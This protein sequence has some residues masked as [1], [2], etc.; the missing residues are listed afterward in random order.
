MV[1]KL[2]VKAAVFALIFS[3]WTLYLQP[4]AMPY[5]ASQVK[6]EFAAYMIGYFVV[7]LVGWTIASLVG[8]RIEGR[9]D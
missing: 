3:I 7:F 1:L 5:L 4:L 8:R 6:N 2:I 9:E